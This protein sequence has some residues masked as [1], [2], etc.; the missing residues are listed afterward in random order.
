VTGAELSQNWYLVTGLTGGVTY[1]F[2]IRAYNKYG[3]GD[4]TTPE[5]SINTSQPPE[6]PAPPTLTVQGGFVKIS[7]DEPTSNH[8]P[9][10][11]Y[12]VEI[13][14]RKELPADPLTFVERSAVCSGETQAGVRYCLVKME[15]LR[16]EPFRLTYNT[17]VQARV[18]ARNERGWSTPSEPNTDVNGARIQV[19]PSKMAAPLRVTGVV[20]SIEGTGPTQLVVTWT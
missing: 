6:Q 8:R 13:A 18:S 20:G 7:W 10:L 16:A 14:T 17:L 19:E 4:F 2:K 9:V 3:H 5:V 1:S 11:G 12:R 15:D